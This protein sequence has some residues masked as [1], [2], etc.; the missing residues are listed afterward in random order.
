[1]A[2]G[3]AIAYESFRT[4]GSLLL[5]NSDF[6]LFLGDL[7]VV[8]RQIF[9]DTAFTFSN[10]VKDAAKKIDP[11]EQDKE[12]LKHPE[13]HSGPPPS[14]D[15]LTK[16]AAEV[17]QLV[18]NGLAKTGEEA[19]K[20]LKEN[21]SGVQKETL[22]HRLRSAVV[23]LRQRRDY[24][25]SVSTVG[26][27]LQR[28]A[29]IYSKAV[30]DTVGTLQDNVGTNPELDRAVKNFWSLLSSFGDRE[31]WNELEKRFNDVMRHSQSDP[32][33][34]KLMT[35][36]GNFAEKLLTD[37]DT[38]ES[39][40]E[41]IEELR[42]QWQDASSGSPLRHDIRN[43]QEQLQKTFRSVLDDPDISKLVHTSTK[44]INVLS[45]VGETTNDELF[46]DFL[47]VFVP[48]LIQSVQYI[49]I[50]RIELSVPEVDLLLENVILE[51]GKTVNN[52]SF[53]PF[54]LRVETYNDLEIRKARFRTATRVTSL[55]TVKA[56]GIT[57]RADEVGFWLRAH[58]GFLQLADEGITSFQMDER[59]M[60]IHI[61]V[62]V[63]KEK[64]EKILTLRDVRVTIHKL[65]YELR[66]S[67]LS[68][69]AWLFKPILR[70]II[71]KVMERQIA[72]AIKDG[73]HAANREL[74]FAR[75]R[76][77]ATR[78]SDPQDL[79]TFVK[80]IITRLT[81]ADD[82]DMY[83]SVGLDAPREGI[84]AGVYTPG[85]VVKMWHEEAERAGE[86]VD[87]RAQDGWKNEVFDV[88]TQTMTQ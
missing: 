87:D 44:I 43:L 47:H 12:A 51:P 70:P 58:S 27:L 77:R 83:T 73:F 81:P 25:D 42:G 68:F 13:S 86:I 14:A 29:K 18:V 62:E 22:L 34:E 59:G 76:L 55:F 88:Q 45:P 35:D 60:D 4:I 15:H 19:A 3:D 80:A 20:S 2:D 7:D 36:V 26:S 9:A 8:A 57:M 32:Q 53:L 41:K 67:K 84:F 78:I 40:N 72:N 6:R 49:P 82:P 23:N 52:S 56:D 79:R 64:L 75:E 17:S 69:V 21:V 54:R 50:P 31:A 30:D 48:L 28:Y 71:R 24:S 39:A 46:D 85:S 33:F 16:E 37:P 63:G 66:K 10:V 38:F 1:M 61:D 65:S 74:L 11:S 5:T